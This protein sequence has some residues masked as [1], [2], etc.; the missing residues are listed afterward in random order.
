LTSRMHQLIRRVPRSA[1]VV[2]AIAGGFGSISVAPAAAAAHQAGAVT[3]G[4]PRFLAQSVSFISNDAGWLLGAA[5]CRSGWCTAVRRTADRGHTWTAVS[6]PPAR[7]SGDGS[8]LDHITELVA[9]GPLDLFA[10][11]PGLWS[12]HDGGTR[13]EPVRLPGPVVALAA[14][15]SAVYAAVMPC[16]QVA[17]RCERG[18]H[19]Y[20]SPIGRDDWRRVP[21]PVLS[22]L[23]SPELTVHGSAVVLLAAGAS[24]SPL[25]VAPDGDHFARRRQPCPSAL[26]EGG[27]APVGLAAS[28]PTD[29]AILCAGN[30]GAGSA[31][32]SVYVSTDAA[33]TFHR[34]A[35]PPLGGD[36]GQM[37]AA[38]PTTFVVAAASGASWL[39]RTVGHDTRWTTARRFGDGGVGFTDLGFSDRLHGA[40]IYGEA[41]VAES[42]TGQPPPLPGVV[43]L[44]NSGGRTWFPIAG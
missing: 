4:A 3:A 14:G 32:K 25:L 20:R 37:A 31:Q 10:F 8:S 44:T 24:A 19:L 29:L 34:I 11:R 35:D 21:G 27:M 23:S 38:S 43:Y 2:A 7:I 41:S 15:G 30:A 22:P 28:G 9:A 12:S 13:W 40:A 5:R 33:R 39:Y 42:V 1:L 16:Y 26:A 6:A 36:P 18:G 17:Q